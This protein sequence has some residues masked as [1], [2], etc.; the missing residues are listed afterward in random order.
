MEPAVYGDWGEGSGLEVWLEKGGDGYR[1]EPTDRGQY[2]GIQLN[3]VSCKYQRPNTNQQY[4][5][6]WTNYVGWLAGHLLGD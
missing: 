6:Y 4:W 5:K 3:E 1:G 2:Q